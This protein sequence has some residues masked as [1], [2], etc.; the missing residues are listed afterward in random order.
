M[1]T[2]V[3]LGPYWGSII[4]GNYHINTT[5]PNSPPSTLEPMK[6]AFFRALKK[7]QFRHPGEGSLPGRQ[8]LLSLRML[9]EGR[10]SGFGV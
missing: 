4:L 6:P 7:H 5:P 8:T 10:V 2:I 1:R 3:F 9:Q